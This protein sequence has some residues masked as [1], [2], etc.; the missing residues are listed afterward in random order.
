MKMSRR[1]SILTHVFLLIFVFWS[2]TPIF[3]TLVSSSNPKTRLASTKILLVDGPTL[4]NYTALLSRGDFLTWA[5]N[6]IFVALVTT[7][8]AVFLSATCAYAISRFR[9]RGRNAS[10][11][12][13]LLAQMFPAVI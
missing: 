7:V 13:F 2:V 3:W 8:F 11:Y 1:Q 9:Y 12:L 5:V 4:D 6:S 10:I